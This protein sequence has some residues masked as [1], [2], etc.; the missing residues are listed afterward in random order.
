MPGFVHRDRNSPFE[1]GDK[2]AGEAGEWQ[3]GNL[4]SRR[5]RWVTGV[6]I[7]AANNDLKCLAD[8]NVEIRMADGKRAWI[9]KT[10]MVEP[11]VPV[12]VEL[13]VSVTFSGR[14]FREVEA[15]EARRALEN[16]LDRIN[17]GGC[18]IQYNIRSVR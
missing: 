11:Y 12:T 8:G 17:V 2:V 10:V 15:Q 16:A 3:W 1:F 18:N 4:K 14:F 9:H 5:K 6:I 7:T 13:E